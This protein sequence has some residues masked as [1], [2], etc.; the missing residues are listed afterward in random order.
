VN[1]VES[2]REHPPRFP[3]VSPNFWPYAIALP[4]SGRG[5]LTGCADGV[6]E[7]VVE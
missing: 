3:S 4:A 6:I 5:S 7:S 2:D 1:E